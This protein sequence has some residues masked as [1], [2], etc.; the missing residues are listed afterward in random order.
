[1]KIEDFNRIWSEVEWQDLNPLQPGFNEALRHRFARAII[2]QARAELIAE[3]NGTLDYLSKR[4]DGRCGV[5]IIDV[6][7][8]IPKA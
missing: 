8:L 1:M 4:E 6:R 3:V 7:R 2:A 5:R